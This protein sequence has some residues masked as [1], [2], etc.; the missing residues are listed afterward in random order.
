MKR[1]FFECSY[2]GSNYH[3]WQSQLNAVSVQ[4][5]IQSSINKFFNEKKNSIVGCGR[6]DTGVHA[7]QYFFHMDTSIEIVH[8]DFIYKLN[9]ILP[10]DI[11]VYSI[12]SVNPDF[13]ARFSAEKR[14][15][16]YF[17]SINKNPFTEKFSHL[18]KEKL[19]INLMNK[20]ALELLKHKD[21]TSFSKLNTDVKNNL[22]H[23]FEAFWLQS[24]GQLI[25]QI[26]A[27]RFLRNMVRAIVG[28]MIDVGKG[29]LS[30]DDFIK[31]I[32]DKDR[33]NAGFSAPAKGLFLHE[34]KYP[35]WP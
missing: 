10:K 20:C 12:W 4:E 14:T 21:F 3:G 2:N 7:N 6:T 13:H 27:N 18:I 5:V 24:N 17:I 35:N 34:V 15:Y 31:I 29:K 32:K 16:R 30:L 11:S 25:F 9:N 23:I 22:C 26:S 28:T 1:Y 8:E 33:S 19:D